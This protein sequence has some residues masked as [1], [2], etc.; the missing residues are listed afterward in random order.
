MPMNSQSFPKELKAD[1]DMVMTTMGRELTEETKVLFDMKRSNK[2]SEE[3]LNTY[4]F[5]NAAEIAEGGLAVE[6]EGGESWSVTFRHVELG[7]AFTVTKIAQDDNIHRNLNQSFAQ[8]ARRSLRDS[9]EIYRANILNNAFSG[10][11]LGGDGKALLAL[12]HPLGR[13]GAGTY[14]NTLDTVG[15]LSEDSL[16]DIRVRIR[17]CADEEGKPMALT[18]RRLIIPPELEDVATRLIKT[19]MRPGTSDNDVSW[20][21]ANG[22]FPQGMHQLTR[23]T[24]T[25]AWFVQTDAPNGLI[26]YTRTSPSTYSWV[27]EGTR[28]LKTRMDER[29]SVGWANPRILFGSAGA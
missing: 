21:V 18:S 14:A 3:F 9:H 2:A 23:L 29:F 20:I 25:T 16:H 5:G 19:S 10:S 24:S 27:E 22:M 6:D 17:R 1:I 7:I 4:G 15:Q 11:Y 26:E 13:P 28:N 12:D 8:Q